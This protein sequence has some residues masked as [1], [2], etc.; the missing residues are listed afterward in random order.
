MAYVKI[1]ELFLLPFYLFL[2]VYLAV[3][4]R[5]TAIKSKYKI[6]VVFTGLVLGFDAVCMNIVEILN[7][8]FYCILLFF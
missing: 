6:Y 1:L 5:I 2:R 7:I 8:I 4:R 3:K